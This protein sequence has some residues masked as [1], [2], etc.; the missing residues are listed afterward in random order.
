MLLK[1]SGMLL[2]DSDG[3]ASLADYRV[4]VDN[5]EFEPWSDSVPRMEI[6]SHKVSQ[7]STFDSVLSACVLICSSPSGYFN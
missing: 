2:P 6:E 4:R 3:D 5:G 1:T 7:V